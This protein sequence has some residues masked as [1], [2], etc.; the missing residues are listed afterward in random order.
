MAISG[1]ILYDQ[2]GSNTA[3]L[4]ANYGTEIGVIN[5]ATFY[6]IIVHEFSHSA[7]KIVCVTACLGT[8]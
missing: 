4:A 3:L 5:I 6:N 2:N 8:M 7:G 1:V